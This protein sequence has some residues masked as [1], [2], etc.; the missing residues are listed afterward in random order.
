M[1]MENIYLSKEI[2]KHQNGGREVEIAEVYDS[3]LWERSKTA[4]T[5]MTLGV[6]SWC[7]M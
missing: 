6:F 3:V 4:F 5:F 2:L 1:P 7:G